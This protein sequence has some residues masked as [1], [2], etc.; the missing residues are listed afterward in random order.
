MRVLMISKAL[1]AGTSQRKLEELAKFPGVELILVTP[2]YWRSDDGSKQVLERLYTNGYRMIVTPMVLNG[3]FHLHY[4][5]QLSKIMR[6]IR[7]EIVHIDEE[8]YNLATFQ[9]M[10]LSLKQKAH[11][12]FFTWQNL[13]RNY[14]PPFR[15][16]ELY[17]YR[18]ASIALAGNRD[19]RDVLRHKGFHSPIHI[20]PQFGFDT[21]IYQ[22]SQPRPARTADAPFTL[23]YLGRLVENKGLALLIEALANLPDYCRVVFIGNGPLKS[24]LETLA[25]R[26]GVTQ[27]ITF[28]PGLPTYE[29][30]KELQQMD[31]LVLPSLTRPNWKEQF[32]R[33]LAEAMACETPVIGSSSGEIPYVIGD[34]G[35]VFAEGNAQ[36]LVACVRKLLEDPVLYATLATRGRQRVLAYYTQEQIARQTYQV[37]L[38]VMDRQGTKPSI[39]D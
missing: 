28:K 1:V 32:G 29:V 31:V 13:N 7:P 19:A 34:A 3:N 26:L 21:E 22:R 14:P 20:I 11:T 38:E 10:R 18:H 25:L 15:Q 12:L 4:Y 24:E 35:L 27:R 17:N 9:A 23:G 36:K 16:I 5:P 33:V 8:P 39:E 30:P 37:Y 6:E 2:E